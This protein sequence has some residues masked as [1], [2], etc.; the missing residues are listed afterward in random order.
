MKQLNLIFCLFL[1]AARTS[2]AVDFPD[3]ASSDELRL[4]L[5]DRVQELRTTSLNWT[6]LPASPR[7]TAKPQAAPALSVRVMID[8]GHGGRDYGAHGMH[9]ILEK[10]LCLH[11]SQLVRRQLELQGKLRD[12]AIDVTLTRDNDTFLPLKE[13]AR[14][15]NDWGAD[16]FVSIHGNSADVPAAHGFE[17]YFLSA[18]STDLA[19]KKLARLENEHD[20]AEQAPLRADVLSIL[21]DAQATNHVEESSRF[22]ETVFGSVSRVFH[23]NGRGVRQAPFSVLSGTSMP[24]LLIEVGYLTHRDE[25]KKLTK[26]PYLKRLA[27]AISNGIIEFATQKRKARSGVI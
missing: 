23:P 12:V 3:A 26:G 21:S 27:G 2:S 9:G 8:P 13:R 18:S 4:H 7:D 14:A 15:A 16:L 20:G 24:A 1:L 10:S 19:A 6:D 22:A 25:A 11:L 5:S 17:V